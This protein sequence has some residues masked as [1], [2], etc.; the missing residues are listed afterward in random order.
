VQM[1]T[2]PLIARTLA[3]QVH[4]GHPQPAAHDA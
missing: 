2:S 1:L 4:D 3:R